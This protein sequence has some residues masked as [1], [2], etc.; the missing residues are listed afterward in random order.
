MGAR[1]QGALATASSGDACGRAARIAKLVGQPFMDSALEIETEATGLSLR[2]WVAAPTF[3]RSQPDLQYLFVNGRVVKD[4]LVAHAIR[5]AYRDVMYGQRHP[6][7]V[8]YLELIPMRWMSMCIRPSMKF[9][10]EISV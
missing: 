2:G 3:S 9:D 8:P 7:Y 4:R 5:Q 6:A 10:S 1:R